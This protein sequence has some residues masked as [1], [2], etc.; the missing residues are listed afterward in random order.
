MLYLVRKTPT[1]SNEKKNLPDEFAFS[2][3]QYKY[4]IIAIVVIFIGYACMVGGGSDDPN[5]YNPDIFSFR[6]ITLGPI[7]VLLGFA[8]VGYTILKKPSKKTEKE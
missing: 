5:V 8:G 1:M 2:K 3:E 7:L 4:L 6:R